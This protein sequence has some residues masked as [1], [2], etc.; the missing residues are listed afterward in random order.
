MFHS[1][2]STPFTALCHWRVS[3]HFFYLHNYS[4]GLNIHTFPPNLLNIINPTKFFDLYPSIQVQFVWK[5]TLLY[6]L[7]NIMS[8]SHLAGSYASVNMND[9]LVISALGSLAPEDIWKP[10]QTKSIVSQIWLLGLLNQWRMI[11]TEKCCDFPSFLYY[12]GE[13]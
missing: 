13:L 2:H 10:G 4:K 12:V 5:L 9:K 6:W 11:S 1:F 8:S 3:R 7:K